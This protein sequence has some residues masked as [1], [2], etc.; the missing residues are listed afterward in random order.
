L[1]AKCPYFHA[2]VREALELQDFGAASNCRNLTLHGIYHQNPKPAIRFQ[3]RVHHDPVAIFKDVQGEG[4]A[5]KENH[6]RQGK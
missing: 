2:V 5:W 6:F 1:L 3:N 4:S